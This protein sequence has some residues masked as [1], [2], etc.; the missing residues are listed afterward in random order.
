VPT[1]GARLAVRQ[2][3]SRRCQRVLAGPDERLDHALSLTESAA[4]HRAASAGRA[5][6][7]PAGGYG[8]DDLLGRHPFQVGAGGP[9]VRMPELALDHRQRNPL[10]QQLDDVRVA[11]LVWREPARYPSVEREMAQLCAHRG[12]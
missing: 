2:R 4:K 6:S 7:V 11:E 3:R 5:P 10:V 12:R 1:V 9:E 8:A